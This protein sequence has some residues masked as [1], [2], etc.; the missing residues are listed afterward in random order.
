MPPPIRSTAQSA[1]PAS[2]TS[3]RPTAAIVS[4]VEVS[5]RR[6]S[7]GGASSIST[8]ATSST[9]SRA[10]ASIELVATAAKTTAATPSSSAP[11]PRGMFCTSREDASGGCSGSSTSSHCGRLRGGGGRSSGPAGGVPWRGTRGGAP[12][13]AVGGRRPGRPRSTRRGR[14]ACLIRSSPA[15]ARMSR[16]KRAACILAAIC[17]C[18][19]AISASRAFISAIERSISARCSAHCGWSAPQCGQTTAGLI[20]RPHEAHLKLCTTL[21][22]PAGPRAVDLPVAACLDRARISTVAGAF[23]TTKRAGRRGIGSPAGRPTVHGVRGGPCRG[24][25]TRP[26]STVWSP[27][28]CGRRPPC[29]RWPARPGRPGRRCGTRPTR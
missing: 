24:T 22:C 23:R 7:T 1:Y 4:A 16:W 20:S 3:S 14:V 18:S 6:A 25:P 13:V 11:S 21:S 15:C 8:V 2:G 27:G 26:A 5:P 29:G 28:S 19:R 17:R 10:S 9:P 12:V